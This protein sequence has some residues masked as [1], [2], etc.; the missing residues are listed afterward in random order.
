MGDNK[1]WVPG[2]IVELMCFVVKPKFP[3]P[4]SLWIFADGKSICSHAG[5]LGTH[6]CALVPEMFKS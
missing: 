2:Y 5:H 6:V 4:V 1:I 3:E